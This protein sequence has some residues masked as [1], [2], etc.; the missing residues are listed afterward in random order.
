MCWPRL[1]DQGWL[2]RVGH[3]EVATLLGW[4]LD[5]TSTIPLYRQIYDSLRDAIV[6]G[7]LAPRAAVP[8]TRVLAQELRVSRN[9]TA[10][11]VGIIVL[12]LFTPHASIRGSDDVGTVVGRVKQG[13]TS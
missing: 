1:Q 2:S 3:E 12:P 11:A 4:R 9:T 8:P 6:S 5:G 7:R 13:D 10:A